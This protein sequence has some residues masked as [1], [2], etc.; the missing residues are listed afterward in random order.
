MVSGVEPMNFDEISKKLTELLP[1]VAFSTVE[2]AKH[3][4]SQLQTGDAALF[5]PAENLVEACKILR[6]TEAFS[7]DCL[8]SVTAIDRKAVGEAKASFEVVYHLFSYK[9]RHSLVLKVTLPREDSAHIETVENIWPAAN[10]MEREVYDLFG[11]KFDH[12]SD[13]RRIM[14]PDDWNGHPLRKDYKEEE[15]YH[16]ITTTRVS[17]IP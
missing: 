11:V 4:V 14:L 13:L 6:S 2:G 10:W 8:S 16:G 3:P 12:H 5:L 15:D 7:F 1:K 17:I 9:H